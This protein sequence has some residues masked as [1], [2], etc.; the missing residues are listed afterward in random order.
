MLI[1]IIG[2]EV[3]DVFIPALFVLVIYSLNQYVKAWAAKLVAIVRVSWSDAPK[4]SRGGHSERKVQ[5]A[6]QHGKR[7]GHI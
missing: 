2:I 5:D 3:I 1:G 4:A 7:G 6:G